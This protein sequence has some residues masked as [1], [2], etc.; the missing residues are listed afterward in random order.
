MSKGLSIAGLVVAS[1]LFLVFGLDLALQ[2]PFSRP[3]FMLDLGLVISS[4]ILGYLALMTYL[5][6][7]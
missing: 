2:I 5:E 4:L 7:K 1:I 6:Q 3:S